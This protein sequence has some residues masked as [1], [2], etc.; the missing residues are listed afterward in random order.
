MILGSIIPSNMKIEILPPSKQNVD[1]KYKKSIHEGVRYKC[2][3][4]DIRCPRLVQP[5]EIGIFEP[6]FKHCLEVFVVNAP[7]MGMGKN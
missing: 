2:G 4:C 1:G 7:T 6:I 5:L 3:Q